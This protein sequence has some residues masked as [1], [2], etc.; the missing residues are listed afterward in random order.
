MS[1]TS[2]EALVLSR[3]QGISG[4]AWTSSNTS[5]GKWGL[6]NSGV[7]DHYAILRAGAGLNGGLGLS[8]SA[9][10]YATVI[11]VWQSY[12]D[13]GTSYTNILGYM[14]TI[15]DQFDAYRK[16]GDTGGTIQDS[17]CAK[18]DEVEEMWTKDGGPRWLR[19]K[20]YIEWVEENAIT[21]AE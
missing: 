10:T 11:E 5:R 18:W 17:R 8:S 3:L 13:D 20:F 7:S 15:L 16:L 9:R 14:E 1:Y 6:L 12:V 21:Y 19:Q 2:G 4:G